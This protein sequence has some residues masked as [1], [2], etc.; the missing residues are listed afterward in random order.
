MNS[1]A[2]LGT[3][4]VKRRWL[5]WA[6]VETSSATACHVPGSRW[7]FGRQKS[8]P[9]SDRGSLGPR[10]GHSFFNNLLTLGSTA[11]FPPFPPR[12]TY[13]TRLFQFTWSQS[14]LTQSVQ[15][16]TWWGQEPWAVAGPSPGR[17]CV[18][19]STAFRK[20]SLVSFLSSPPGESTKGILSLGRSGGPAISKGLEYPQDGKEPLGFQDSGGSGEQAGKATERHSTG[21]SPIG[22]QTLP[23]HS[24][25]L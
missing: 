2:A 5:G 16:A 8:R 21:P 1:G 13:R 23:S 14:A 4:M 7:A 25:G 10:A 15:D 6:K 24:E 18:G 20:N 22:G 19:K 11:C 9:E 12:Q 17:G 3:T